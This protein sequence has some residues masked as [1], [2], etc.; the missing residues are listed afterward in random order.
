MF[1][2]LQQ[3]TLQTMLPGQV[4]MPPMATPN[5]PFM[6]EQQIQVNP[7][8]G[9]LPQAQTL[10]QGGFHN[11]AGFN[12][13]PPM[14][15][16]NPQQAHLQNLHSQL[17]QSGGMNSPS[18]LG[19]PGAMTT[20][21]PAVQIQNPAMA[22]GSLPANPQVNQGLPMTPGGVPQMPQQQQLPAVPQFNPQLQQQLPPQQQ[23]Q[24]LSPQQQTQFAN[25]QQIEQNLNYQAWQ[26]ANVPEEILR[27][28][29]D[30][31]REVGIQTPQE[32]QQ[33]I[34]QQ[35]A[36]G[37]ANFQDPGTYREYTAKSF[38]LAQA[39][40]QAHGPEK[41]GELLDGAKQ[42]ILESPGGE[43]LLQRFATDPSMLA[44]EMIMP[45]IE[46]QDNTNPYL[47][48]M[49]H[50]NAQAGVGAAHQQYNQ[51]GAATAGMVQQRLQQ[52]TQPR[53]AEEMQYAHSTQGSAEKAQL[54]MQLKG[55]APQATM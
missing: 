32:M 53:T 12:P 4:P 50:D 18:Q 37:A 28:T 9:I 25:P 16:V 36:S 34:D 30:M 27:E 1:P 44:P 29:L 13:Q 8:A 24:Q 22:P 6:Q 52:L 55:V 48:Y 5:A 3:Q 26:Q 38:E 11:P 31:G 42:R 23:Q 20:Q 2:N 7:Q 54:M 33:F 51:Q 41:V 49:G 46:G 39:L 17:T 47:R 43:A 15:G 21:A 35:L 40:A 14:G 45:Y 19:I 10:P